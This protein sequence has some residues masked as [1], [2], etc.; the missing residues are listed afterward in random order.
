MQEI[1]LASS[2]PRRAELLRR[3]GL[4]FR[5]VPSDVEERAEDS[6]DARSLA[7]KLAS[8]KAEAVAAR[9]PEAIVLAADTVVCCDGEILG[10][11]ADW[12]D[13]VRM[14]QLL[15][16]RTH[17][18][19]TGVVLRREST[20]QER[21]EVVTTRVTFRRLSQEEILGYL[22]TGEPFDKAGAYGIQGYGALLVEGIEGC[23]S[24]VVGLPLAKV[25]EM[26]REFGVDLLCRNLNTTSP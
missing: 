17:E 21:R 15:S 7:L 6:L 11:P 4:K 23:Y 25:G 9:Y 24:N 20:G 18:V 2:S 16:G 26:L 10:K 1:I 5:V 22:A 13:A 19:S 8:Q 12:Q 3:V 14:L